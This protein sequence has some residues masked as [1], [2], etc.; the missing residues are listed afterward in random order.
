MKISLFTEIQCPPGAAA[1]EQVDQF[2]E[3]AELADRLGFRGFW[4]AEIHCQPA[5]SQLSSPYVVLGAA[6][7]RTKRL[8]LGVAVNTL[9]VHH[10]VQMAEAAATLDLVS[11]GRM[12]FAAGG[13][14]PHSRV[15][16]CFGV[17]HTMT[18][19]VVEESL[20]VIRA[21]WIQPVLSFDGRFFKVPGVVVNPK[22]LQNPPPPFYMAAS[23]AEGVE[24]A[25]RAGVNLF[26]PIHTRTRAQIVELAEAYWSGLEKF[27]HRRSDHELGLLVPMHIAA[28]TD[29]ARERSREGIMRYYRIIGD[30]RAGYIEWLQSQNEPLPPRLLKTATGELTFERVCEEHAVIGDSASALSAV[31]EWMGA[32]GAAHLLAWMNIGSVPHRHVV[33]SMERF[34]RDVMPALVD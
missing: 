34:A 19:D 20:Q 32:T 31:R 2:L 11:H 14:H 15:Y 6:A 16:E 8:R 33:E 26:L 13:G 24:V 30:M 7:A 10:P 4:I 27:G 25:A 23:S 28:S 18:H 1:V 12:D 22:P 9:P 17:D 29:E 21:A 3:Q 5:F